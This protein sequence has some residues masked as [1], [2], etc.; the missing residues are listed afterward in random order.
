MVQYM[1]LP[2]YG[3]ISYDLRKK[4]SMHLRRNLPA[5][6][7]KFVFKN[8]FTIGSFFSV[9]DKVPDSVCSRVVYEF[10][11][12]SCSARYIGCTTRSFKIRTLEHIG[13][14]FRTG[15]YLS[16]MPFSAVRD[17]STEHDHPFSDKDFKILARLQNN[18]DTFIAEKLLIKKL[19]PELNA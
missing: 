4:L 15:L 12:P 13:K 1:K 11:C 18:E 6:D 14:S 5:I 9:K 16:K 19:T 17:H 8:D 2:Y 10:N 3:R 7:F